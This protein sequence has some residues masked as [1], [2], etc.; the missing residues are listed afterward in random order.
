MDG[1]Q[2]SGF[3]ASNFTSMNEDINNGGNK[4]KPISA[5]GKNIV[6][7]SMWDLIEQA[8]NL[9]QFMDGLF[10]NIWVIFVW[11][12]PLSLFGLM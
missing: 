2:P 6:P 4:L 3:T 8:S 10:N 5:G 9:A 1:Q 11:Y 7:N 12:N